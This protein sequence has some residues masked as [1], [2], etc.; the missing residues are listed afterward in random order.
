A[1]VCDQVRARFGDQIW[2]QLRARVG[3]QVWGQ[4]WE[5]VRARFGD[6]V[7]EQ[8]CEQLTTQVQ[9]QVIDNLTQVMGQF[10]DQ[11]GAEITAQLEAELWEQLRAKVGAPVGPHVWTQ[12]AAQLFGVCCAPRDAA[13]LSVLDFFARLG[14]P[15]GLKRA[16]GLLAVAR[17]TGWWWAFR[18]VAILTERP[19]VVHRDDRGRL[20][21]S[22]G[23]ALAY[24]D[25]WGICAWH[26]VRVP[27]QVILTPRSLTVEQIRDEQN[28]EVRRVM[29]ER[30]GQERYL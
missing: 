29:L 4:A 5:E 3:Y 13:W 12:V 11:L 1:E 30:F 24:P 23:L 6:Q 26:G 25:G 14:S 22:D 19:V 2:D 28:V 21:C 9:P 20:H 17:S 16:S 15:G 7:C 10:G 8:V 18:D 27:D